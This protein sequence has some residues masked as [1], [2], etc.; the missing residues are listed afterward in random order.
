MS[1][2]RRKLPTRPRRKPVGPWGEYVND[3][4]VR[5]GWSYKKMYDLVNAAAEEDREPNTR[6]GRHTIRNWI[7]GVVP[8]SAETLRWI[9][10][11]WNEPIATVSGKADA[12]RTWRYEQRVKASAEVDTPEH[13]LVAIAPSAS[14][15]IPA[16]LA[17]PTPPHSRDP[18]PI[19]LD[20][21]DALN[22][23]AWI[24]STNTSDDAIEYLTMLTS[25]AARDHTHQPPV[26][27]L[28]SAMDSNRQIQALLQGGR[29]RLRQ[30]RELFQIDA[31]LLAHLCLLLGDL[32]RDDAA[33]G[34]GVASI[35]AANEAGSSPAEAY[36]AQAQI[37]RWRN[38]YADAADLAAAGYASSPPTS[39]RVLLS[40]QEA[41]AA[42]LDGDDKRARQALARAEAA[43]VANA[44]ESAWTCPPARHALYRLAVALHTGDPSEA[45]HEAAIAKAAWTPGQLPPFGT[46]AHTRIAAGI[47]YL[48]LGVIDA[49]S[50]QI[51][52]VLELPDEYRLATLMEHMASFDAVLR[53]PRFR[54]SPEAEQLRDQI[55]EYIRAYVERPAP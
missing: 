15:D 16:V 27:V 42:A 18:R 52:P 14:I 1:P 20:K 43:D 25:A 48:K 53:E 21:A 6:Y 46:S 9:A 10:T 4:R 8:T 40:C 24:E 22:L 3:L 37:A 7:G 49:A 34:Y 5:K 32:R 28:K 44:A 51:A 39:L 41:N 33:A 11:A 26:T 17:T 35:L 50:H 2:R 38:R 13:H 19:G 29:Q 36:S 54:D 30:S 23:S 47:A 31:Q 45:L 12:H 55:A